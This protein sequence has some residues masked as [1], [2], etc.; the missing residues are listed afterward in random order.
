MGSAGDCYD[1]ALCESFFATLQCELLDR[2]TFETREEPRRAVFEYIQGWY[3]PL[4]R[5][6][7][8]GCESPLGYERRHADLQASECNAQEKGELLGVGVSADGDRGA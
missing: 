1:N 6:S 8:L 2:R 7:A 5:H 3:N 4:R